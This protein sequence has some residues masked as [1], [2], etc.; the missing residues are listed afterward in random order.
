MSF[1]PPVRFSNRDRA[2]SR[3]LR[4]TLQEQCC[5]TKGLNVAGLDL[6]SYKNSYSPICVVDVWEE[7]GPLSLARKGSPPSPSQTRFVGEDG[8]IGNAGPAFREWSSPGYAGRD[9]AKLT[10]SASTERKK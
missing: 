9:R 5:S 8:Q 4:E 7:G 10:F 6:I 2:G 3:V 1:S